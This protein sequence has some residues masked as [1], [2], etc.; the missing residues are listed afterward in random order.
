M[1]SKKDL[2]SAELET[3]TASRSPMTVITVNGEVRTNEEAA[4]YVR[5]FDIF[6]TMKVLENTPA[7]LSLGQLCD[8]HG[9]SYEW[10]NGQKP[11]SHLKRYWNTVQHGEL[12]FHRGSRLVNE[13]F[14]SLAPS[15]PMTP[16]GQEIDH[17][18]HH[19]ATE[20]SESVDRQAR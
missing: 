12:R 5:E 3:V 7:V 13:F 2:N 19:P 14:L 1:I 4:V 10:I 8:E 6:L 18:D 16:S 9:Y 17:S 11:T 20:S 15:T